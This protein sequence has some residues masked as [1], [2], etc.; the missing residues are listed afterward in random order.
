MQQP[1]WLKF[2]VVFVY[3][4]VTAILPLVVTLLS[5]NPSYLLLVPAL[6]AAWQ[7]LEKYLTSKGLL[8]S[9]SNV[10]GQVNVWH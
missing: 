7:T 10:S 8:G 3:Q 4:G 5:N 1:L 6:Q 9:Q 2:V